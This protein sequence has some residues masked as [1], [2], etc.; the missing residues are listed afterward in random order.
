MGS[1]AKIPLA[2]KRQ[3]SLKSLFE[4]KKRRSTFIQKASASPV[5]AFESLST[6]YEPQRKHSQGMDPRHGFVIK[7]GEFSFFVQE[8]D[9]PL[10]N[11]YASVV[12]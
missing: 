8:E 11:N 9:Q 4:K 2:V 10:M 7:Q 5:F 12:D 1:F 6:T 3:T